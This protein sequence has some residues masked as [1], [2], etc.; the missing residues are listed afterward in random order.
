MG[1][2]F[3][4]A[5]DTV[6]ESLSPNSFCS[7]LAT[8][9]RSTFSITRAAW[10]GRCFNMASAMGTCCPRI[11]STTGRALRGATRTN[12]ST[13]RASAIFHI[14]SCVS[15]DARQLISLF[16]C[17]GFFGLGLPVP[18]E[19]PRWCKFAQLMADHVLSHKDR[20]EFFAVVYGK[21]MPDHVGNHGG[22]P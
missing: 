16:Q 5:F 22:S 13:A 12:L 10:R 14:L 3:T 18:L 17:H 9:D 20:N 7:A 15:S 19:E 11:I 21:R 1:P 8:A 4:N 6:I 2:Q